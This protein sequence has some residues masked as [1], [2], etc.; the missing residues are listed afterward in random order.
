MNESEMDELSPRE[1]RIRRRRSDTAQSRRTSDELVAAT[2]P[3]R[4]RQLKIAIHLFQATVYTP[5]ICFILAALFN[6]PKG[7]ADW[8][9]LTWIAAIAIVDLLPVPTQVQESFSL[10]FPLELAVAILYPAPV[11]AAVALLGSSDPRELH[12]SVPPTRALFNRAQV[13]AAVMVES[14]L[15]HSG[16]GLS[17]RWYILGLA[18]L[19]AAIGG[20]AVNMLLVA[21]LVH[22]KHGQPMRLIIQQMHS[23]VFGEF[24]LSY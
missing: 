20:Y 6:D 9:L 5:V 17:S 4:E 14:Y 1:V 23:G 12:L 16:A 19:L 2:S 24:V 8:E 15:F 21:T 10:G 3:L 22:F 13:A 7:F 11:A 18:V